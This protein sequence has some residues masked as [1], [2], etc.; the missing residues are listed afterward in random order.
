MDCIHY[1]VIVSGEIQ[2]EEIGTCRKCGQV[3]RYFF[4]HTQHYPALTRIS[5]IIKG[6]I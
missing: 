3:K 6:G 2:G 5:E 1:E 4:K